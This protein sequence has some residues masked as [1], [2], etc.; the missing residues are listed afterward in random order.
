M[1]RQLG[2]AFFLMNEFFQQPPTFL[3]MSL[4]RLF[5][6]L[7]ERLCGTLNAAR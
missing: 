1:L 2:F 3:R 7:Q 6:N 4:E 5:L